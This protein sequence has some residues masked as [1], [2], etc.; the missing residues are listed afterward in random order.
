MTL[1]IAIA[2]VAQTS[3]VA[4]A[5]HL[6][7]GPIGGGTAEATDTTHTDVLP[8]TPWAFIGVRGVVGP[9]PDL[10]DPD[11]KS[12]P[13]INENVLPEL[14]DAVGDG[15]LSVGWVDYTPSTFQKAFLDPRTRTALDAARAEAERA[16][17]AGEPEST[18]DVLPTGPNALPADL[19]KTQEEGV[20]EAVKQIRLQATA[21][22]CQNQR[23]ILAGYSEGA[24][25]LG[26][27]LKQLGPLYDRIDEVL[28][29]GDPRFDSRSPAARRPAGQEG[30][31]K[32]LG[33][34]A[35]ARASDEPYLPEALEDRAQSYC[36]GGPDL[37]DPVCATPG[38]RPGQKA[39]APSE[40]VT[41]A[42]W[43]DALET[44][45]PTSVVALPAAWLNCGHRKYTGVYAVQYTDEFAFELVDGTPTRRR[46]SRSESRT[47]TVSSTKQGWRDTGL[48]LDKD[49]TA[50]IT[51]NSGN[52]TVDS[53]LHGR[54]GPQG[55]SPEDDA[56]IAPGCKF[57]DSEPYG[58]LLGAVGPSPA[59]LGTP[60]AVTWHD[61]DGEFKAENAGKLFLRINDE[62]R[63]LED[64]GGLI[65]VKVTITN[66]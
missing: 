48:S 24:W 55:Y 21:E 38:G 30:P 47:V 15:E 37:V 45:R 46:V 60:S 12:V 1:T 33:I 7:P 34:A 50:T 22:G 61:G 39:S 64:N 26:E 57:D 6:V 58:A 42:D 10:D 31:R 56:D 2:I 19:Q 16:E 32:A 17:D 63:C 23:F 41:N 35:R 51:H 20:A 53:R 14:R 54:V 59:S 49:Q 66:R 43:A 4:A 27:A 28:L 25:V 11:N 40:P 62:D 18:E 9:V 44:C 65:T 8:C 5:P 36:Y 13:F 52:W 3:P 29:F